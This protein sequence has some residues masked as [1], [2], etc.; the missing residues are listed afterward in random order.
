MTVPAD[1]EEEI[2][3]IKRRSKERLINVPDTMT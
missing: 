1:R 2:I 3:I